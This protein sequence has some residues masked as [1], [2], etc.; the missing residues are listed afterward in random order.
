MLLLDGLERHQLVLQ[1][2]Q[3]ATT[4]LQFVWL[5]HHHPQILLP[6]PLT[7]VCLEQH[8]QLET[9]SFVVQMDSQFFLA[10]S[11]RHH[12]NKALC[13]PTGSRVYPRWVGTAPAEVLFMLAC[14]A[15]CSDCNDDSPVCMSVASSVTNSAANST[16]VNSN[17][18]GATCTTGNKVLCGKSGSPVFPRWVGTAPACAADC[19][20]CKGD[21]PICM[22]VASSPTNS[23][24]S[25]NY[26]NSDIFG[27]TCTSGNKALCGPTGSRV[28]PRW[29]GTAPACSASCSD[30]NGDTPV[31]MSVSASYDNSFANSTYVNS[32]SF[33]AT[34]TSGNKALCG[35]TGSRVYPRWVGTA[36][37]CAASCSDCKG[38]SPICM[39][40]ASS[41]SNSLANS[42]YAN[43]FLFGATCTTG[44]KALCGPSGSVVYARW[45]G[46]APACSASCSDCNGDTPVCMSVSASYD[47]SF[48]NSTYVNSDSFG[49]T[50]TSG[51]KVLCGPSGS[52]IYPRWLGVAPAC[53]ASCSDCTGDTPVCMSVASSVTTSFAPATYTDYFGAT[54]TSGNKV[55]CGPNGSTVYPRW[56]GTA[57]ACGASCSDCTGDTPVCMS[58]AGS[59][60]NSLAPSNLTDIFGASCTSGNKV[61]CGPSG[62][63]IYPRWLGVAPACGA[64]CS[65]CTG[66]TP[67]CMSVASSVTT[68]FAPATYTDYFGA[69]CTSGN[70]VLCGP[71][72]STIYPRWVGTAPA[73]G[74]SCS[75]CTGNNPVCMAVHGYSATTVASSVTSKAGATC[76]SGN[77]VLCGPS[78]S[79]IYPRWL[80]VAPACGA[81]CSDCTGDTPVCMSVASSVTTSFAPATYT[82]YFGA[83]CTSG[84]KVLCG[85]N[86][87]TI[88][89]RWVGTAPSCAASC[90]DCTGTT[91]TCMAEH[92]FAATTIAPTDVTNSFGATCTSGNKVLC[93][94]AGSTIYKRWLGVAP[95]CIGDCSRCGSL[96][97]M[98][99]VG[100]AAAS[101][102]PADI[103]S[104]FGGNCTIGTKSLCGPPGSTVYPR[105]VGTA[106]FCSG[107]CDDCT[108]ETPVCMSVAEKSSSSVA[109]SNLTNLFG[110]GCFSGNKALCGPTGSTVYPR[111]VGD[112]PLC[113]AKCTDCTGDAPVC[114]AYAS[115]HYEAPD[116]YE[117]YFGESC[118]GANTGDTGDRV[119]CGP[120]GSLC[121][122]TWAECSD[123]GLTPAS[124]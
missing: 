42:T 99:D 77:K 31:C 43:Q 33:G 50:C 66:D 67:V 74:A 53:G 110:V 113:N 107:S 25:V 106:P 85:P 103:N 23:L 60:S 84:N 9:K 4:I 96:V 73:C 10:G 12:G 58:V 49:A 44:N 63:T 51:N 70:K 98:T 21:T 62:S 14:A 115:S 79:T 41:P 112:V 118:S 65:D 102:A 8:A 72:G 17:L 52:T 61:L 46:T 86:G 37:A 76:T 116:D 119:L 29:V 121:Y 26:A 114:M 35:P 80:G 32:D 111:W 91:P 24:A 104:Y 124:G 97:C 22:S 89:P 38:D 54:C 122:M 82:D 15:S 48:A 81:S 39:S 5:L 28:Y 1:V 27:A 108:H 87:S 47:N 3:I 101:L 36:P 75:D 30:C 117:N 69:T 78:G 83:T 68:S 20:D 64:S 94:P 7:Q 120:E 34:C 59:P 71:N 105:W 19:S 13:G 100:S 93:G 55:L 56:V 123:L 95:Y 16:Y 92:G 11:E 57:P 109:P 2:V 6:V 90:A 40:V 88:Y 18:F 45:V